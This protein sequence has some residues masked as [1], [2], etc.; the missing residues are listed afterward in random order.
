MSSH[1][2]GGRGRKYIIAPEGVGYE[3]MNLQLGGCVTPHQ[4]S[5]GKTD[6]LSE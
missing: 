5:E 3:G 6:Q 2:L 1:L 4:K